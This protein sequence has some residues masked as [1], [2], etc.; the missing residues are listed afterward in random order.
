MIVS[1]P[2]PVLAHLPG[3]NNNLDAVRHDGRLWLASRTAPL[4]YA[5]SAARLLVCWSEDEG[6]TWALDH[7]VAPGRDVREPRLVVWQDRLL[8]YWFTAGTTAT[9]FEPDR[10]WVAERIDGR[11][12]AP[13]AVSPPDCVV[14]RVRPV[15]GLLLMTLY[16][17]AGALFTAHPV[18]LT[19]ELWASTDGLAWEPADPE[20]PV[21]HEGGAEADHI[22]LPDGRLVVVVRK[23]GP[24]GGWGSDIGVAPAGAPARW[25]VRP[26]PRKLDSPCLFL[27]DGMPHLVARRQVAFGGRYDLGLRFLP[28]HVRT[29]VDQLVYALTPKRTAVYRIDPE[30]L[31]ATWLGDLPSAGDTAFAA[32][33]PSASGDGHLVFNYTSPVRRR[34]WPWVVGQL[35]P[36]SIYSVEVSG[37]AGAEAATTT[38]TP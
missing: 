20:R 17:G 25:E 3:S 27:D 18:P 21:V 26:D 4:H 11:L 32:V 35:R 38:R 30:A 5:S 7:T 34:W 8:L 22:E 24:E 33:V 28:P 2:R 16:R 14:W 29:K 1:E 23:E 31:T 37:L 10:I 13:I 36:T 12:S 9:R 19:V 6:A 15:G